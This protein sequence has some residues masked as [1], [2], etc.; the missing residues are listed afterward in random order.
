VDSCD[1]VAGSC[2]H[3]PVNGLCS[4][5]DFCTGIETCDVINDCQLGTAPNCNDGVA[6]TVDSCS[7][8][9]GQC[10]NLPDHS[11]CDNGVY[12]DGYEMC[13]STGC[14]G[15]TPIVCPDDGFACTVEACD[16]TLKACKTTLSP[17][18]NPNEDCVPGQ[19]CVNTCVVAT[20]QGKTYQCG[21]CID[22]DG[23]GLI[24]SKDPDCLGACDNNERGFKGEIPGQNAAPCKADCYFDGD[25]GSGNDDCYWSHSCDPLSV[26]PDYPPEGSKCKY[27]PNAN[28]PGYSG[29]C[30]TALASQST[31]CLNYC[32]PLVPNGCDC[33]GCCDIPGAPTTVYLGSEDSGGNG[34]CT[35]DFLDDPQ[36]CKPCTVVPSCWNSCGLCEICIGKPTV[37]PECTEADQCPPGVQACGLPGQD[38]CPLGYYCITGCCK[39]LAQ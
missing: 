10:L 21:D 31:Q 15:G 36:K 24:D 14:V 18:P 39:P 16:E 17:C 12:C 22:N 6:C 1:D 9:L 7:T 33:F 4:D 27:D 11:V 20:C 35:L 25:T 13:T 19:G 34:T 37:P 26:A 2:V 23:D 32:L 29:T 3:E 30:Q 8:A 38:P 28:I 5:G